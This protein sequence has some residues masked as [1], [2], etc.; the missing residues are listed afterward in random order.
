MARNVILAFGLMVVLMLTGCAS[1]DA[2][3]S[4]T[5]QIQ[6][7]NYEEVNGEEEIR[8][9]TVVDYFKKQG[10]EVGE[11]TMKAFEMMGAVDGFGIDVEGEQIELYLFDPETANEETLANLEDARSVGKFSMSGFS[12]SVIMNGNILLTRYGEHSEKDRILEV[13]KQFN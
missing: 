6:E 2:G 9:E 13:F 4:N 1:N 8:L 3:S 11:V 7:E 10:L 12:F 5:S